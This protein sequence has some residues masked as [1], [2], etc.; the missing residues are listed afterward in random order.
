MAE[1]GRAAPL[2]LFVCTGNICRSPMAAAIARAAARDA[3]V[4]VRIDSSGT[5]GIVGAAAEETAQEA[6]EEIGLALHDHRARQTTRDDVREATR[7]RFPIRKQAGRRD[8]KRRQRQTPA[9]F[10]R[11][12]MRERLHGLAEPH[13]V[14]ENAPEPGG[15]QPLQPRQALMLIGAQ[16]GA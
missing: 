5:M 3:G 9:F 4:R 10:L 12:Q 13:R 8:D 1:D 14:G 2:L 11:Q 7:L 15:T 6:L 16:R